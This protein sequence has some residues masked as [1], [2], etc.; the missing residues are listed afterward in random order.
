MNLVVLNVR[1]R[2]DGQIAIGLQESFQVAFSRRNATTSQWPCR[3]KHVTEPLIVLKSLTHLL[4][5]H[6]HGF[7]VCFGVLDELLQCELDGEGRN[8]AHSS[9]LCNR[10]THHSECLV[11][12]CN[13]SFTVLFHAVR[14]ATK[15]VLLCFA[16][17]WVL[18][19]CL[20][21]QVLGWRHA[22]VDPS[23]PT[24]EVQDI[25]AR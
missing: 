8:V 23:R 24:S 19:G 17:I 4:F 12:P 5:G 9:G 14:V 3:D 1:D 16:V 2:T 11:G 6:A 13:H 20:P 15:L 18:V 25:S 7:V 21:A 10:R 22:V